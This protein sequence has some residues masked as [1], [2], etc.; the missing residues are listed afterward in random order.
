V[1]NGNSK[2]SRDVKALGV[3][4]TGLRGKKGDRGGRLG[5][6]AAPLGKLFRRGAKSPEE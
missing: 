6:L 1:L 3:A 4:V 5:A 2:F